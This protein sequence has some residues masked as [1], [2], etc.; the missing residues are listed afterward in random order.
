LLVSP[1]SSGAY[2]QTLRQVAKFVLPGP[3]GKRFDY[4]TVDDEDHF[5]LTAHLGPGIMYVIDMRSNKVVKAIPGL[6]GI[7]GLE[8]VPET[9]KVYTSDWG[10]EKIGIVDLDS[11]SVLKRLPTEAKPNGSTYAFAFHKMYV[12]NTL[13]KALTVVDTNKDEIVKVFKFESEV[14]MPQYDAVARKV[15][16][17]LRNTNAVA[18]IDPATDTVVG[19]YPVDGCQFNHGM[20]LDS[21][22]H[23]AFLLCSGNRTF[24]VFALDTH[25]AIAHLPMPAGADVVKFDPGLSRIYVACS[26]GFISVF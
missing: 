26:S 18:E 25:K 22:H 9:R 6:P 16:V 2:G 12:A 3:V 15:Y 1:F 7:T 17:N 4:L 10:E 23:R 19:R 13:G 5:L 14:G 8:F 21:R 20:A 11:M 24:T